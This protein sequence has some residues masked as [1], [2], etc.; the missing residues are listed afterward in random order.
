MIEVKD[1]PKEM[2]RMGHELVHKYI[3]S[4]APL[5]TL[6]TIPIDH[7][8]F[9][10]LSGIIGTYILFNKKQIIYIGCS[11][12]VGKRLVSHIPI[13]TTTDFSDEIT[14]IKIIGCE[15]WEEA[16]SIEAALI[17]EFEPTYNKKIPPMNHYA[18]RLPKERTDWLKEYIKELIECIKKEPEEEKCQIE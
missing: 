3:E 7:L 2:E 10:L 6:T 1:N 4:Y 9:S 12:C 8:V 15:N 14:H 17:N 13:F 11:V 16:E 18:Y 5:E